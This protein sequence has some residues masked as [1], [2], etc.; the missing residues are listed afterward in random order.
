[1]K[2]VKTFHVIV[3]QSFFSALIRLKNQLLHGCVWE[4]GVV[5]FC[6]NTDC[7]VSISY[8]HRALMVSTANSCHSGIVA[9]SLLPSYVFSSC[10]YR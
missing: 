2:K 4:K 1:M 5:S 10:D 9:R 6:E 8:T 7:I 3:P